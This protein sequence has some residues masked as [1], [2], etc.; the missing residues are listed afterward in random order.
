MTAEGRSSV[1]R[2]K[3]LGRDDDGAACLARCSQL[4]GIWAI[5]ASRRRMFARDTAVTPWHIST[6]K[7]ATDSSV[8]SGTGQG[9]GCDG[10]HDSAGAVSG[11]GNFI[12]RRPSPE[13][14]LLGLYEISKILSGAQ[15]LDQ[16]LGNVV[17]VLTSFLDMRL[18]MIVILDEDGEPEIV[19]TAGW[20]SE[21]KGKPIETLPHARH[22][23]AGRHRHAHHGRR[24][25]QG[26][27]VRPVR[28]TDREPDRGTGVVSRRSR[29]NRTRR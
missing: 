7:T 14:S 29:S 13:I 17:N 20:A 9:A 18:G 26:S 10:H 28:R 24:R 15:R 12:R 5:Q 3:V 22:R 19:A 2:R 11:P 6:I 16:T 1:G 27:A 4:N 8:W 23:P 25:R 21:A